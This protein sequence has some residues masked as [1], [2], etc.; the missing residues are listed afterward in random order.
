MASVGHDGTRIVGGGRVSDTGVRHR[1][2]QV[3]GAEWHEVV[4]YGLQFG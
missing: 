1:G 2:G 4:K 3:T